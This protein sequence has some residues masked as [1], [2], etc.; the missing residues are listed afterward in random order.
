MSGEP[1][2]HLPSSF[3]C[4]YVCE[5]M[6][7]NGSSVGHIAPV[8]EGRYGQQGRAGRTPLPPPPPSGRGWQADHPQRQPAPLRHVIIIIIMIMMSRTLMVIACP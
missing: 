8:C 4:V 1:K 7:K 6:G 3:V 5:R 2:A